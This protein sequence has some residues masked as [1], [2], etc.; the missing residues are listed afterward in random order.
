MVLS[1]QSLQSSVLKA[2]QVA[3]PQDD[4]TVAFPKKI[5]SVF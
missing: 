2:E 3:G 1:A 4:G 5:F